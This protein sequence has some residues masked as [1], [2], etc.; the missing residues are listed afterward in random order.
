MEKPHN[1]FRG[2]VVHRQPRVLLLDESVEALD[3]SRL[4]GCL[5]SLPERERAVLMMSFYD[6]QSAGAVGVELGLSAGNVRV[7]RH[8]GI[9]RLRTCMQAW[10][11][12]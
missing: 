4:E 8:R 2:S 6:D 1:L 7:I 5:Q 9:E 12:S 3:T 10:E 11:A